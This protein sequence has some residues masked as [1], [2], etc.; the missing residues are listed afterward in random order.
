MIKEAKVP[1][2]PICVLPALFGLIL[3]IISRAA[4]PVLCIEKKRSVLMVPYGIN[5]TFVVP[6]ENKS[7]RLCLSLVRQCNAVPESTQ[8]YL[9]LEEL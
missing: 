6:K 7:Q 4:Y 1:S 3:Y 5:Y 2:K 9:F 8:S